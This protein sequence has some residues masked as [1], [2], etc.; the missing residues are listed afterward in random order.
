MIKAL[1]AVVRVILTVIVVGAAALMGAVLGW[2]W[3]GWI[4]AIALGTVG[5]GLGALLAAN[6]ELLLGV[7]AEM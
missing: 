7:L 1:V 2:G 3:H 5:F 6:P 4:G